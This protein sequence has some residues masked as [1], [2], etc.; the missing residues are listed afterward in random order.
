MI[1]AVIFD[2][3]GVFLKADY[4]S[5]RMERRYGIDGNKFW[6]SLKKVLMITRKPSSEPFF[7]LLKPYLEKLDLSIS[8]EGFFNFWFSGEKLVPEMLDYTKELR[9][10]GI[11]V[12]ILSRNF[13]ER[14]QYYRQNFLEIFNNV[15]KAYFSWETGF[16]KPDPLA[17]QQI[18]SENDL[19][20]EECIYFDDSQENIE[21]AKRLQINAYR[22]EGL[23]ET[24]EIIIRM[25][26]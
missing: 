20:P 18:L 3:N 1:K 24:K 22:Y 19:K 2:F 4:L 23:K 13:K 15:D 7:E 16:V 25:M 17:Y 26:S 12:F 21:S 9:E 11:R 5:V 6:S 10:Q 8:E 14:T